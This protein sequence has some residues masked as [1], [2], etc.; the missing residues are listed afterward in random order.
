MLI[1]PL[2]ASTDITAFANA[3]GVRIVRGR[4]S[5]STASMIAAP[6]ARTASHIGA[7]LARTGVV[8]ASVIPSASATMCIEFAVPIP[9]HTP[10]P[11][12]ARELRSHRASTVM[13]PDLT[14][15]AWRNTSSMSTRSPLS[16]SPQLW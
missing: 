3:S 7:L 1:E 9:V 10:G 14:W 15:L 2:T 13:P 5:A 4:R 11:V 16:S 8:P 12:I 6:L